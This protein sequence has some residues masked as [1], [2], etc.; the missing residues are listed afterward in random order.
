LKYYKFIIPLL[1]A[2]PGLSYSQNIDSTQTQN[3]TQSKAQYQEQ[4]KTQYQGHSQTQYQEQS[5]TQNQEQSQDTIIDDCQQKELADLLRKKGKPPKLPKK[6]LLLILPKISSNPTNGFTVGLGVTYGARFGPEKTTKVSMINLS[7]A[8]TSKKQFLSF[9]KSNV[10]TA[11]DRFFL[12]GDW[13]FNV[14][15]GPTWGLGTSAPD[16]TDLD[17][18]WFWEGADVSETE[19]AFGM[20]YN[21]TK[22]H[23]IVNYEVADNI[24]VGMGYHLDIYSKIQD[25]RL[26]LDTLPR[27]LTPHYVYSKIKGFDETSYILSGVSLNFVYDSRDNLINPYEGNYINANYRMNPQF[28]GSSKNSSSLLLEYRTYISVSK[29]AARHLV[30]FWFFGDFQVTGDRPY[31]TLMATAEDQLS[32]S[33]RGYIGGRFRGE[34]FLYGEVEYRFPIGGCNSM[35]GGVI[36][37]NATTA[38]NSNDVGL[39][40]YIRPGMGV[41]LRFLINKTYRTNLNVEIARGYKSQGF[42]LSGAET[43]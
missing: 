18:T 29:K 3:K 33:G 17:N 10:F 1:F 5:Q 40:D 22:I 4:S 7:V 14:F 38:S 43:F 34:N 25:S 15:N 42:Y 11:N 32:R 24:F 12:Q 19:G 27:Q 28:L 16:T 36:F 9:I 31:L 39:F 21:Y 41:G 2:I 8:V 23:E 20:A 35:I 26:N 13:R 37:L 30:G 6:M